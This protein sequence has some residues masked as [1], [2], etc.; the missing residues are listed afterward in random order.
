M[1]ALS[2]NFGHLVREDYERLIRDG[3]TD[4]HAAE[5]SLR[6]YR[7]MTDDGAADHSNHFC[8]EPGACE[9]FGSELDRAFVDSMFPLLERGSQ[10]WQCWA[11]EEDWELWYAEHEADPKRE[12]IDA[13]VFEEFTARRAKADAERAAALTSAKHDQHVAMM[14]DWWGI[15]MDEARDRID[16][17]ETWIANYRAEHPEATRGEAEAARI[18]E[19]TAAL[20]HHEGV[21]KRL[22]QLRIDAEARRLFVVETGG[23]GLFDPSRVLDIHDPGTASTGYLIEKVLERGQLSMLFADSYV[24]KSFLTLDWAARITMGRDWIGRDVQSGR[25]LYLAMEG[26]AT[27]RTRLEAWEAFNFA[28]V[29]RDRLVAYPNVVNLLDPNSLASLADYQAQEQFDLI[30]VDTLSRSISGADE[31]STELMGAYIA[32]LSRLREAHEPSHVLTVHH[33]K[34]GEVEVY[35]GSTTLG[36]GMDAVFAM[37]RAN[38]NDPNDEGRRLLFQ[39]T[40][41]YDPPPTV[42]LA[43]RQ[44]PPS[45]VLVRDISAGVDPVTRLLLTMPPPV[46][47]SDLKSALVAAGMYGSEGSANARIQKLLGIGALLTD[48]IH[49]TV[50]AGHAVP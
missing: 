3:M 12:E 26:H 2:T 17:E 5:V 29:D 40:K 18:N 21:K 6:A 16:A 7:S 33:A 48:G 27:L 8:E 15:S 44:V 10:A 42:S 25:V 22:E 23:F 38:L 4:S 28:T 30:V 20:V 47:R 46:T 32:A 37:R 34:K 14:A 13:A 9:E 19:H 24:G 35:R 31:N 11:P 39:K 49:I 41:S 36:A 1:T 43:F 50:G 45:A